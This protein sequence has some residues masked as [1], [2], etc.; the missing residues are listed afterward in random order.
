MNWFSTQTCSSGTTLISGVPNV[1]FLADSNPGKAGLPAVSAML[2][3]PMQ[4]HDVKVTWD[5]GRYFYQCDPHALL[6][7]TGHLTVTP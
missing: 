4:M 7:M 1:N 3:L 2:Q 6:G 5:S